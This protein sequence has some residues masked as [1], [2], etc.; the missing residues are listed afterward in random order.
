MLDPNRRPLPNG[1][2]QMPLPVN[3]WSRSRSEIDSYG[4]GSEALRKELAA[5]DFDQV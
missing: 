3:R 5:M 4:M 1:S 2:S